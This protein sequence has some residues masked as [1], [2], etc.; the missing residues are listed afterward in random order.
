MTMP[1]LLLRFFL[2]YTGLMVVAWIVLVLLRFGNFIGLDVAML[3]GAI[4]I[5][6]AQFAKK[7]GRYFSNEEKTKVVLGMLA[8]DLVLQFLL[9]ILPAMLPGGH[10]LS[11][12]TLL[13][14]LGVVGILHFLAISLFVTLERRF[15]IKRGIIEG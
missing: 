15:L 14:M 5:V 4:T 1:N 8:I 2:V 3:F 10:G 13:F 7:N 11:A 9:S 6:S 12:S